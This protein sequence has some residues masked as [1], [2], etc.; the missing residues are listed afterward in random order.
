M[1]TEIRNWNDV[2]DGSRVVEDTYNELYEV[3][4]KDGI[5]WLVQVGWQVGNQPVPDYCRPCDFEPN[6]M[7]DQPWYIIS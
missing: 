2:P 6:C 4:T 1:I 3:F 5:K 7:Y